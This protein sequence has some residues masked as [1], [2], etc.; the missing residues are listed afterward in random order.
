M[1]KMKIRYYYNKNG[2]KKQNFVCDYAGITYKEAPYYQGITSEVKGSFKKEQYLEISFDK[3]IDLS[4]N[5]LQMETR[6]YQEDWSPYE[7]FKKGKME[8]YYDDD[9]IWTE[10]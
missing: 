9:L 3:E 4:D 1:R 8:I 7:D 6:C 2:S 5:I 10:K